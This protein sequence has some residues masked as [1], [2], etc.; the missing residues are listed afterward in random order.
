M[1]L[2]I[3]VKRFSVRLTVLILVR[4]SM[5]LACSTVPSQSEPSLHY[6]NGT[7][8]AV[9]DTT[10]YWQ[11]E[12]AGEVDQSSVILRARLAVKETAIFGDVKGQPGVG[13]FV[14]WAEDDPGQ[15]FQTGW[16]E[17]SAENDYIIKTKITGLQTGTRYS[18]K[19]LSGPRRSSVAAGPMGTFRTLDERGVARETSLVAVTS[20]HRYSFRATALKDLAFHQRALGFPSL[21]PIVARSPDYF[22]STGDSV[23]YDCPYLGRAKTPGSMRAKWHKQFATPRFIALFQTAPVYWMKDDHDYRYDDADPYGS[24]DPLAELGAGIFL[25][26]V[27]VVDP[28]VQ[29]P[30][31]YRTHRINDLLQIWLLEGRDYRDQNS[32]PAGPE[33]TMWG[34]DQKAWLQETLAGSDA[35]FKLI[36][37]PTPMVGPDDEWTGQQGGIL[38]PLFGGNPLGQ[39]GDKRKRDNHTNPFGFRAEAEAFFDWLI[40]HDLGG[41]TVFFVCGDRHWQYHSI[42]P[43]GLEEFSVGALVDGSSRLGPRPGDEQSTDPDGLVLQP[44]QQDQPGGGFLEVSVYPSGEETP[45]AIAFTFYDK[46]GD[47]R[48]RTEREA[49]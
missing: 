7:V 23:Y 33:K 10:I 21:E 12:M 31:T 3:P 24:I 42:H 41:D 47:G 4:C 36:I 9:P 37:S 19:L 46:Y 17:A 40:D 49:R 8:V 14:M 35:T 13:A 38:A 11:G 29:D 1:S 22:I 16:M 34:D 18:Y 32:Q 26:Q 43:L 20:M 5:S 45:A 25:E 6:G 44:Y 27:P 30:V 39:E 15:A 2:R 28:Q 48:Y